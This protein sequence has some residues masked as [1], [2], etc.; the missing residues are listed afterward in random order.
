LSAVARRTVPARQPAAAAWPPRVAPAQR[1]KA[2]VGTA[3]RA[4]RQRSSRPRRPTPRAARPRARQPPRAAR[5]PDCLARAADARTAPPHSRR[6]DSHRPSP[7]T[8]R[9]R[10]GPARRTRA[11]CAA[12]GRGPCGRGTRTRCA[13]GPSRRHG[14]GHAHCATGPSV[15]SAQCTRLNFIKFL[16]IQFFANSKICVGFI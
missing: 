11:T 1:L 15:N 5:P 14:V 3:R 6:P 10:A 12:T 16:F 8:P 2:A 7:G 9:H 4:S 13:R